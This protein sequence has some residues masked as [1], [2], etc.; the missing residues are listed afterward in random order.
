M[1]LTLT[2]RFYLI[3]V[4]PVASTGGKPDPELER[5]IRN[6]RGESNQAERRTK[7]YKLVE[8]LGKSSKNGIKVE[9]IDIRFF[10]WLIGILGEQGMLKQALLVLDKVKAKGGERLSLTRLLSTTVADRSVR[11]CVCV[12]LQ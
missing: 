9:E 10:T 8:R 12:G 2:P 4:T 3:R 6:I 1:A 5:E 11:V 7:L